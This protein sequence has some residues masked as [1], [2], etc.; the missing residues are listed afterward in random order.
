M[1]RLTQDI[2]NLKIIPTK[3]PSFIQKF[4]QLNLQNLSLEEDDNILVGCLF[5][6]TNVKEVI[7]LQKKYFLALTTYFTENKYNKIY[8]LYSNL[9]LEKRKNLKNP[10]SYFKKI[11][12]ENY[13]ISKLNL[14]NSHIFEV[15][16]TNGIIIYGINIPIQKKKVKEL[17]QTK[18]FHF[19]KDPY[20]NKNIQELY[21]QILSTNMN[22]LDRKFYF[23]YNNIKVTIKEKIFLEKIV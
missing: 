6:H 8:P 17:K 16:N 11:L 14:E 7:N 13:R 9:H 18:I 3:N 12:K 15:Y 20:S 2:H 19:Y 21:T 1:E 23:F 22:F 4:S 5:F 10:Q